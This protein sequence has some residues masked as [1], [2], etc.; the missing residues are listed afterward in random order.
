[1]LFYNVYLGG[2]FFVRFHSL[3]RSLLSSL[4]GNAFEKRHILLKDVDM[5]L[6]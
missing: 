1:M 4:K 2:G 5:K 6:N 3:N